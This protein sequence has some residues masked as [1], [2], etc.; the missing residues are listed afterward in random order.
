M[1]TAASGSPQSSAKRICSLLPSA[2]EIVA[3]LGCLDQL[4][5]RSAECDFPPSVARLPV[6]T[7]A[8]IDTTDLDS[9]RSASQK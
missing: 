1:T 8:R 4:V 2:T 5:G 6:V 3:A 7:S 9:A